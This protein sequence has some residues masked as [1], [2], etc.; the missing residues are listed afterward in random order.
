MQRLEQLRAWL[1]STLPGQAFDLAPASADASFRRYFRAT[2][3]D[4]SPSR[5]VMDAPPRRRTCAL[6]ARGRALPRRRRPCARGARPGSRA[7]FPAALR[8]RLDDL[9]A[10]AE[11]AARRTPRRPPLRRRPRLIG[12]NPVRQPSG[13]AA[14][15]RSCAA[16][17]R[18]PA[19]P[20]VVRRPPQGCH[21][22]RGRDRDAERDVR[23]DPRDQPRRTTGLRA[24]RLSFAQP[25]AAR[26][27]RRPRHQPRHHRLPGREPMARSPTTWCRCSR[28]PTSAGTRPSSSTC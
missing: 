4:G 9:P 14:G 15:I 1:A 7:G 16:A 5:I 10:G 2:F 11:G 26:A 22:D 24:S 17:A 27:R 20:G 23:Q 21:T 6:A 18:T 25:D 8:P 13:G 19:L 28:T 3:A 12:R